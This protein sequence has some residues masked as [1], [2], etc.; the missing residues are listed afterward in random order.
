MARQ[1]IQYSETFYHNSLHQ[2]YNWKPLQNVVT[3]TQ[4]YFSFLFVMCSITNECFVDVL[5]FKMHFVT[6]NQCTCWKHLLETGKNI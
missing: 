6:T 5:H 4:D 3:A 2:K 1:E